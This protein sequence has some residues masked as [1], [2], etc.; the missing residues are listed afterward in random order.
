MQ[1]DLRGS[2]QFHQERAEWSNHTHPRRKMPHRGRSCLA[3][4][5]SLSSVLENGFVSLRVLEQDPMQLLPGN[6]PVWPLWEAL[7][8]AS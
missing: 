5:V 3:S 7:I 4:S 1:G 2:D 8:P 6:R